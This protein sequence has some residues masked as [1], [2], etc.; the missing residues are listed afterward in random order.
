LGK[1]ARVYDGTAWQE[2]ASAQTD[3]TAYST[4]AQMNTAI[5]ASKKIL[6]VVGN[7]TTTETSISSGTYAD[8]GLTATITPL[9]ASSKILVLISQTITT[10]SNSSDR[11]L[12]AIQTLRGATVVYSAG[13]YNFASLVDSASA[14]IYE[15]GGFYSV[16]LLDSP[17][18]TSATT[19][20]TQ[21]K[22]VS[23]TAVTCQPF[24]GTSSI[25][26]LEVSA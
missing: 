11:A 21:V 5:N 19:Y 13:S 25:V 22:T 7:T 16:S 1:K 18:T 6:Q 23:S 15:L 4:T 14:G 8:S 12:A 9:F 3:L 2:L 17:A 26:L 24:S 20:K 10:Y